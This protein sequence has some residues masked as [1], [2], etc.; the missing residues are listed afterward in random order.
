MDLMVEGLFADVSGGS[1]E[2]VVDFSLLWVRYVL[3][4]DV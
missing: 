2:S 1:D 3:N 4:W